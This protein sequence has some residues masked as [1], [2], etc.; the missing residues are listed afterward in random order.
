MAVTSRD[1][2]SAERAGRPCGI[3]AGK[4]QDG[5]LY[6]PKPALSNFFKITCLS[7]GNQAKKKLYATWRNRLTNKK[8]LAIIF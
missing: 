3:C 8:L 5:N 2:L 6:A 1:G 7:G 4:Q